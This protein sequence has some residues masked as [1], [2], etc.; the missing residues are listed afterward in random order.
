MRNPD[1]ID[2]RLGPEGLW[3]YTPFT[4]LANATGAPSISLPIALSPAGLPI[5]ALL[6]A[7][8]GADALLL[9]VAAQWE[10]EVPTPPR[11]APASS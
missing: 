7:P 11:L 2:Y 9:Q 3:R 10:A 6:T 1:F 8:H 4:P 5:G